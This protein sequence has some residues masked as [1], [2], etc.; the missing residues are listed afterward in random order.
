MI[1]N[2]QNKFDSAVVG[3]NG[4]YYTIGKD[5][6][7]LQTPC[8]VAEDQII[9]I[10]IDYLLFG[11]HVGLKIELSIVKLLNVRYDYG[12]VNLLIQDILSP[13]KY[14]ITTC[15]DCGDIPCHWMLVDP[16]YLIKRMK[17][18]KHGSK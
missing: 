7:F 18:E 12:S 14:I 1:E 5:S 8:I 15:L 2:D 9:T 3:L 6:F 4:L 10:G 16:D 13:K 11:S 17:G